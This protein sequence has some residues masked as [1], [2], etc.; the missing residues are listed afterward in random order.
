MAQVQWRDAHSDDGV[1]VP[2][3][4]AGAPTTWERY[5]LAQAATG[6]VQLGSMRARYVGAD[7]GERLC[8]ERAAVTLTPMRCRGKSG[9]YGNNWQSSVVSAVTVV[10]VVTWSRHTRGRNTSH[11]DF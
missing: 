5:L 6:R 10:T 9:N 7:D 4:P 2:R 8:R 3:Y 1:T 11:T